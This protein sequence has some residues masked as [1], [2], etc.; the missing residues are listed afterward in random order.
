MSILLLKRVNAPFNL[1]AA[2][3]IATL[4]SE[5]TAKYFA[6]NYGNNNPVYHVFTPIEYCF[7]TFIYS[8]FFKTRQWSKF[9]FISAAGVIVFEIVNVIFFQ[10]LRVDDTNTMIVESLLLMFLSLMLFVRIR[11]THVTGNILLKGVF[12]FNSIVLIYYAFDIL[13]WGFHSLKVYQL[14]NP[15]IIMYYLM[16]L[17]SALLYIAFTFSIILNFNNKRNVAKYK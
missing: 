17:M 4:I 10:P 11:T 6:V 13:V 1:L 16:F 7:Y 8:K 3:I 5:S 9:L 15:P 2:L 14:K 12:W